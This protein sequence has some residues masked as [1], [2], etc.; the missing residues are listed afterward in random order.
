MKKIKDRQD[1]EQSCI[2]TILVPYNYQ[3]LVKCLAALILPACKGNVC[4]LCFHKSGNN[5][6]ET[7]LTHQADLN[8]S[9]KG[10]KTKILGYFVPYFFSPFPISHHHACVS[11]LI[12]FTSYN[13]TFRNTLLVCHNRTNSKYPE[14][15]LCE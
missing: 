8:Q 14:T 3:H 9:I 13:A 10:K 6:T 4:L 11:S 1:T 15:C 5:S 2:P 7:L 12:S